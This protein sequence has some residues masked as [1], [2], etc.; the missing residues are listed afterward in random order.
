MAAQ[1]LHER[2]DIQQQKKRG[3]FDMR[4]YEFEAKRVLAKHGIPVPQSGIAHTAAD[5]Q[6][7]ATEIGCPVV[8][9]A[10]VISPKANASTCSR[11]VSWS[12]GSQPEASPKITS[13]SVTCLIW[14]LS[15]SMW[16]T[17]STESRLS[18]SSLDEFPFFPMGRRVA[19]AEPGVQ[20]LRQTSLGR[21]RAHQPSSFVIRHSSS[22][23]GPS[24]FV[25]PHSGFTDHFALCT[26]SKVV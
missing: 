16:I 18:G 13:W 7:L 21:P 2:D 10:Q 19:G 6:R 1:S 9:K 8:V 22:V 17:R 26:P 5:A 20:W 15:S 3:S 25:I 11:K 4:F 14:R 12:A 24:S 23:I